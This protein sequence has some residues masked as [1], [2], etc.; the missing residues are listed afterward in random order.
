MVEEEMGVVGRGKKSSGLY[1]RKSRISSY[2][3]VLFLAAFFFSVGRVPILLRS[4]SRIPAQLLRFLHF[5]L[6]PLF[7]VEFVSQQKHRS[8][9]S[10][11]T[12]IM[13]CPDFF[14]FP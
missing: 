10:L 14:A 5:H 9:C 11:C 4:H 13:R 6:H 1:M 2:L 8:N 12:L 7:P 3:R